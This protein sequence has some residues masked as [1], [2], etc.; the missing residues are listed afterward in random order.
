LEALIAKVSRLTEAEMSAISAVV[1]SFEEARSQVA[2][3]RVDIND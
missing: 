3:P 1:D 2:E